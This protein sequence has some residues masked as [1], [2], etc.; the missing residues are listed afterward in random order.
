MTVTCA[1]S[2][3]DAGR[4]GCKLSQKL[5]VGR[6]YVLKHVRNKHA[7]V[8]EAKQEEVPLHPCCKHGHIYGAASIAENHIPLCSNGLCNGLLC[9]CQQL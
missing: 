4:W 3:V 2:A 1:Y 7:A 6:E 8:V 9:S 5:F